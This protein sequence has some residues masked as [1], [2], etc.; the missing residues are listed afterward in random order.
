MCL[1]PRLQSPCPGTRSSKLKAHQVRDSVRIIYHFL[2][3]TKSYEHQAPLAW[4]NF[5]ILDFTIKHTTNR[6]PHVPLHVQ[7][8]LKLQNYF[9]PKRGVDGGV[10][11]TLVS[12][13]HLENLS[14]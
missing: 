9:T 3:E 1:F 7:V 11:T 2:P 12:H 5:I 13:V 14:T 6:Q 10:M 4:P 8:L